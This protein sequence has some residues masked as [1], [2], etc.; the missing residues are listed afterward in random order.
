L[1]L[2]Y[3]F[4]RNIDNGTVEITQGTDN[5]LPQNPYDPRAERGLSNYDVRNYF[6]MY[7]N[8]DLPSLPG[9]KWLGAGWRWNTITTLASGNPFSAVV[10]FDRTGAKYQSGTSPGRPDL[11]PGASSNPILGDPSKYFDA[12]AFA[13]PAAGLY[14]NLARNTLIGPGLATVDLSINKRF[15]LTE[16]M[17]VELRAEAFNLFNHPNFSIPS[18]RA[19]F[20]GAPNASN[21]EGVRVSSAGLITTTQTA[22]RNLQLGLKIIF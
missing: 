11:A 16:K 15:Q 9:P 8:W 14:G 4:S 5:D 18:A 12:N 20:S 6:V 21:P 2:N 7:W 3:T 19:V 10:S 17:G 22:S 1:R 13:L